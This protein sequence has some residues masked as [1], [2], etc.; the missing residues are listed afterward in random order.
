[1]TEA[2]VLGTDGGSWAE[3]L[4]RRVPHVLG[5]YVAA[6]AGI[7]QFVDWLVDR[8]ALSPALTDFALVALVLLLPTV[9][10]LAWRHGQPGRNRWT[11]LERVGVPLNATAAAGVLFVV[12]AGQSLGSTVTTVTV[13]DE[14]GNEVERVVPKTE[15][16]RHVA[17]F[18]FDNE[19]DD[20]GLDWLQYGIP[21][22][23]WADWRQ[24]FFM[25]ARDG[26]TLAE[27]FREAGRS[28]GLDL[29]RPLKERIAR[30]HRTQYYL[31]GE[32]RP[33]EEGFEVATTLYDVDD[34]RP[35]AERTYEG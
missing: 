19:T 18:Y 22:G 12:F 31:T 33:T 8:Y 1:M 13:E 17:L 34:P 26:T 32:I 7:V 24:D 9:V 21:R 3:L 5:A 28:D 14:E 30:E 29:P 20:P 6:T 10:M 15:F 35:L 4:R 11:R 23:V 27:S 16:R 2:E 25:N